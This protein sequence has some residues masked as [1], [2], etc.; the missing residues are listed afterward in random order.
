MTDPLDV[1]RTP[2][3]PVDPDP[4]FAADLRARIER[5]LHLPKGVVMTSTL[6]QPTIATVAPSC[7]SAS[8]VAAFWSGRTPATT[9]S[10]GRR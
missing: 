8:I 1:L 5:A 10:T 2:P 3:A 9:S 4:A 7:C 6:D